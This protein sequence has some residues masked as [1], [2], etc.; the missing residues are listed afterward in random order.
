M[1]LHLTAA[2]GFRSVPS[3]SFEDPFCA[4]PL[5]SAAVGEAQR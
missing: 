2:S 3:G 5:I 4:S 1:R